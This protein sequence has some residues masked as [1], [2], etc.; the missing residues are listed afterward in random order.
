MNPKLINYFR[1]GRWLRLATHY[2]T[3]P[4]K[5]WGLLNTVRTYMSREG[6]KNLRNSLV[7]LLNYV[8]DVTTGR[9]REYNK[10]ALILVVAA[11]IYLVSPIDFIPDILPGGL[12]DDA[13]VLLYVINSI[14]GELTRYRQH[15]PRKNPNHETT[16]PDNRQ[17]PV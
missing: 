10:R 7:L 6:L 1:R 15:C 12:L 17:N 11:L 4:N 5:L 8:T 9:Y 3:H 13:G 16:D 14:Q 2:I